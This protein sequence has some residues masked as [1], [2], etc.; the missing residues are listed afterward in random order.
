MIIVLCS[1]STT[2]K[3]RFYKPSPLA[4]F[5]NNNN[6]SNVEVSLNPLKRGRKKIEITSPAVDVISNTNNNQNH[7]RIR[8]EEDNQDSSP[9]PAEIAVSKQVTLHEKSTAHAREESDREED[10][11]EE[12]EDKD[13]KKE[14]SFELDEETKQVKRALQVQLLQIFPNHLREKFTAFYDPHH[15]EENIKNENPTG[16]EEGKETHARRKLEHSEVSHRTVKSEEDDEEEEEDEA[17]RQLLLARQA[18]LKEATR[19]TRLLSHLSEDALYVAG[20]WRRY[21]GEIQLRKLIGE[22]GKRRKSSS[23]S[24]VGRQWL[25][26]LSDAASHAPSKKNKKRGRHSSQKEDEQGGPSKRV[27]GDV[28]SR[29]DPYYIV[30]STEHPPQER[31]SFA[32]ADEAQSSLEDRT[33]KDVLVTSLPSSRETSNLFSP[34]HSN[35]SRSRRGRRRNISSAEESSNP[36]LQRTTPLIGVQHI[37]SPADQQLYQRHTLSSG[38]LRHN[39]PEIFQTLTRHTRQLREALAGNTFDGESPV[40]HYAASA[41]NNNGGNEEASRGGK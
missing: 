9:I 4:P 21:H 41:T 6:N 11:S 37:L 24:P 15:E 5:P 33:D 25:S 14:N 36:P 17:Y 13:D 10:S 28:F 27:V 7:K 18:R 12:D 32:L 2:W 34:E 22:R 29:A 1:I 19:L 30:A 26:T 23:H 39:C 3:K 40:I 35:A 8:E 16:Q 38:R 20:G 31:F